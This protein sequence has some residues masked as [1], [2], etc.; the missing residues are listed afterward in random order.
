MLSHLSFYILIL[1]IT[2]IAWVLHE[3]KILKYFVM[4]AVI[5]VLFSAFSWAWNDLVA[6][7][8]YSGL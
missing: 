7:K 4:L 5:I 2:F 6:A 8:W 3:A 1:V